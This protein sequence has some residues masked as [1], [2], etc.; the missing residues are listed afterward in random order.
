MVAIFG[1]AFGFALVTMGLI[2]PA[3]YLGGRV[4]LRPDLA[5]KALNAALG[6]Q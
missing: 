1:A 3:N 4:R 6:E 2:D 5:D